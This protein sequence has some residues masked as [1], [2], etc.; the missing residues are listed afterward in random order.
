MLGKNLITA[1]AGN[2]GGDVLGV[3]DVFSTWLYT[4][5]GSTQTITNGIDLAGE[6][7]MV[8]IKNRGTIDNHNV[9]DTE[10][11]GINSLRTN[12]NVNESQHS[13]I[14]LTYG[15]DNFGISGTGAGVNAN[16]NNY[17]SWTFRKAKKF[18]DVVTYTGDGTASRSITHNLGSIPGCVIVK[19]TSASGDWA[20]WHRNNGSSAATYFNLNGTGAA[21]ISASWNSFVTSTAIKIGS[22]EI[23]PSTGSVNANGVVYVAYVFAHDAGGFGDDETESVIKCG[24]Y[25]GNGSTAGPTIDIE[26]E[27]QWLLVKNANRASNWYVFD[28]MRGWTADA[29]NKAL[30]PNASGDES[31]YFVNNTYKLESTGFTLGNTIVDFD[32]VGETFIYIAIRRGP[33]K[34]PE[35]ATTVFNVTTTTTSRVTNAIFDTNLNPCDMYWYKN[36]DSFLGNQAAARLTDFKHLDTSSAGTEAGPYLKQSGKQDEFIYTSAFDSSTEEYA[37]Y[38]FRRAPGFFDV[39]AYTGNSVDF[40][41]INHNLAV[42]PELLIIKPRNGA[43]GWFVYISQSDSWVFLHTNAAQQTSNVIDAVSSTNFTI[44]NVNTV[45]VNSSSYNY[46][47]YLFAT[48]PGISKV[49]SYTGTGT[50]LNVDCGFASGARFVLIKRTDST[51][52]WYVW[53]T[54]RGIVSGNDPYFLINSTATEVTSTDYIDPLSSGFQISSSAPAAINASGGSYIFLAIA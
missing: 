2:A 46:I 23:A 26:W 47:A 54:A 14:V 48:L 34:T 40:T 43:F 11:G 20:V 4:G 53:D 8:W 42:A 16:T 37:N 33:T 51:G 50:T 13:N 31:A 32:A 3:E 25:T 21:S 27:P 9:Y 6:G 22:S 35:D 1:A 39:V 10:R 7:G 41:Q 29:V 5:N 45:Y 52:D 17:A 15:S 18:F 12:L 49:G 24:S 28:T 38:Y 36:L 44:G 30:V 19:A